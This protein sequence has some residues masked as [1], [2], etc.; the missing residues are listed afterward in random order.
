MSW[1]HNSLDFL[2]ENNQIVLIIVEKD[3]A[4][5]AHPL[6]FDELLN[7]IDSYSFGMTGKYIDIYLL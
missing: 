4:L 6:S 2:E 1:L 3:H 5:L 7:T